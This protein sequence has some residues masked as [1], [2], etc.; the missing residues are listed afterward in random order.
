MML[1]LLHSREE[2]NVGKSE[3]A[4]IEDSIELGE[5]AGLFR[6]PAV[7]K[8]LDS[9]ISHFASCI[10][11][12]K[13]KQTEAQTLLT[14]AL[15]NFQCSSVESNLIKQCIIDSIT[16]AVAKQ[17]SSKGAA[18][19]GMRLGGSVSSGANAAYNQQFNGGN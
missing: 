10:R 7:K 12:N 15:I 11:K 6:N 17:G 4:D 5:F 18:G 16:Q 1:L 9:A 19:N 3:L 14:G 13:I 2:P 8:M